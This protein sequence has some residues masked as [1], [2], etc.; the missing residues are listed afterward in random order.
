MEILDNPYRV[1]YQNSIVTFRR[2]IQC[3]FFYLISMLCR[4]NWSLSWKVRQPHVQFHEN[5]AIK[6]ATKLSVKK[7]SEIEI[8]KGS[9]K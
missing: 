8:E 1:R 5:N 3:Q 4:L 6:W 2:K 7:A 9:S